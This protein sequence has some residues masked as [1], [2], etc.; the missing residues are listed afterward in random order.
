MT[1]KKDL[2]TELVTYAGITPAARDQYLLVA[3][4]YMTRNDPALLPAVLN[5]RVLEQGG[6]IGPDNRLDGLD[7]RMAAIEERLAKIEGVHRK[8]R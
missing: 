4:R 7:R 2:F 5:C 1:P 8:N 6:L 3:T